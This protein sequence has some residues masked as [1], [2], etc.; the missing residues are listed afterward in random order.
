MTLPL[1]PWYP[2]T[3]RLAMVQSSASWKQTVPFV[4][5]KATLR[6]V[7]QESKP[8]CATLF[9]S[10]AK[11]LGTGSTAQHELL[12]LMLQPKTVYMPQFAPTSM[13]HRERRM[14]SR[15]T[16]AVSFSHPRKPDQNKT[17]PME[18]N[19]VGNHRHCHPVRYIANGSSTQPAALT[20]VRIPF[21]RVS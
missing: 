8:F 16:G 18:S 4:W 20:I 7:T 15:T 6:I 21:T 5:P 13:K 19:S 17:W 10:A 12:G 2:S 11:T 3:A 14:L 9:A 1:W